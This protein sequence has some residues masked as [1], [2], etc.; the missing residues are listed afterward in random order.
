MTAEIKKSE[1]RLSE[2]KDRIGYAYESKKIKIDVFQ[3]HID[4]KN[5]QS[6]IKIMHSCMN[7]NDG[8]KGYQENLIPS[9]FKMFFDAEEQL[10]EYINSKI[11]RKTG[12]DKI[13]IFC[14]PAN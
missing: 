13:N 12:Y 14:L 1:S 8:L 4:D 11:A 5:V 6:F 10:I 9:R 3:Q 2:I 7:E